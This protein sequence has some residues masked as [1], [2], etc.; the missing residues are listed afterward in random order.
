MQ[1]AKPEKIG[2]NCIIGDNVVFGE[3]V[4]LGHNCI[5]EDNVTVGD[6]AYIDDGTILRSG[7]TLGNDAF[8]GAGCI[9]GEYQM[10]FCKSRVSVCHPLTKLQPIDNYKGWAAMQYENIDGLGS[11]LYVFRLVDD[12]DTL[13]VYPKNLLPAQRYLVRCGE[14][15]DCRTGA[16]LLHFGVAVYCPSRWR[17]WP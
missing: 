4:V 15:E 13:F 3:H 14:T 11:L 9:L 16:E 12:S 5:I 2:Q 6:N 1:S 10:D 7:V 8:V 17:S